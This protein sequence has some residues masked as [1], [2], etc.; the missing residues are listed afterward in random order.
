MRVWII[1]L[2]VCGLGANQALKSQERIS[3]LFQS[4]NLK[5]DIRGDTLLSFPS[6]L[7]G[8]LVSFEFQNDKS[9][10]G[11]SLFSKETKKMI[12][13]PVCNFIER[14]FL[15]LCLKKNLAETKEYLNRNKI[16]IKLN[17]KEY[18]S[19]NFISIK[20]M[21]EDINQP[22]IFSLNN[23]DKTFHAHIEYGVFHS[24]D[25]EFPASRE[26]IFGTD[27]KESD[28]EVNR[29]LLSSSHSYNKKQMNANSLSSLTKI[30]DTVYLDKGVCFMI[31]SLRSDG[32]YQKVGGKYVPL[33]SK[34]YPLESV[35]NL[36]SGKIDNKVQLSVRHRMYGNYTP[37]F[38]IRL[39]D[40]LG[41][42][43]KDFELYTGIHT[44][45]DGRVQCVTIFHN[46]VYNYIH[47]LIVSIHREQLFVEPLVL[48]ADF[49]SNIPQHYLKSL[50]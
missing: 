12:N 17:G 46:T 36:F 22:S 5:K 49:Y 7:N 41:C 31:D 6:I 9:H 33:F 50:F 1:L 3:S 11:I 15:E 48:N 4:L 25:I 40:L 30:N 38:T 39:N 20:K 47:M 44:L 8:K 27:K 19:G 16:K 21:I 29:L 26:L 34:D 14:L 42:F 35:K 32:Y 23:R 45:K 13:E 43:D 24:L 37:D 2:I 18:G 28:E 10:I